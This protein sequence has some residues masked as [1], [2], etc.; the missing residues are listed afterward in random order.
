MEASMTCPKCSGVLAIPSLLEEV[1]THD[2]YR[3]CPDAFCPHCG[4]KGRLVV[5]N[6]D[7]GDCYEGK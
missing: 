1:M 2:P 4:A 3:L 7:R 6:E 5:E